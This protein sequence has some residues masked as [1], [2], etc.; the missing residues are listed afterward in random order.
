[1]YVYHFG[2]RS[3]SGEKYVLYP[4]AFVPAHSC[5]RREVIA[6]L[7]REL[8]ENTIQLLWCSTRAATI[9]RLAGAR[10]PRLGWKKSSK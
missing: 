4:G 7:E 1:M 10:T 8:L 2:V 5:R 9:V 6:Q 3:R